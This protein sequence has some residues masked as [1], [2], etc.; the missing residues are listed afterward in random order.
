M[1]KWIGGLQTECQCIFRWGQWLPG[2][3]EETKLHSLISGSWFDIKLNLNPLPC[4]AAEIWTCSFPYTHQPAKS[5]LARQPLT[6][7]Q[8]C[9][10][11]LCELLTSVYLLHFSLKWTSLWKLVWWCNVTAFP[12]PRFLCTNGRGSYTS[13]QVWFVVA[14]SSCI[15][16]QI[17]DTD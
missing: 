16:R 14:M 8:Y 3:T 4:S 2:A 10:M 11:Q 5:P 6:L 13:T 9:H 1:R 17:T 12:L 15:Q 7:L